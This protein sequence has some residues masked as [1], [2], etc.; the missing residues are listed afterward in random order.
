M[1]SIIAGHNAKILKTNGNK[2]EKEPTGCNCQKSQK[3]KCLIPGRCKEQALVYKAT[4]ET[5]DSTDRYIRRTENSFKSRQYGHVADMRKE[6]EGGTTLSAHYWKKINEG[7]ER[8]VSW[9]ILRNYSKYK[10]NAP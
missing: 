3:A 7:Q 8:T 9:E 5:T 10:T 6:K 1:K 2:K 4:V